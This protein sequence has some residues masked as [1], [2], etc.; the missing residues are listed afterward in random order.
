MTIADGKLSH[1]VK[2][3]LFDSLRDERDSLRAQVAALELQVAESC[4]YVRSDPE[5]G[6]CPL[7]RRMPQLNAED[8]EWAYKNIAC[9]NA[10]P[11]DYERTQRIAK[12]FCDYAA[13]LSQFA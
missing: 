12:F 13:A 5:R 8:A 3:A 6:G 11:G 4:D 10:E 2:A 1:G 9:F 7:A